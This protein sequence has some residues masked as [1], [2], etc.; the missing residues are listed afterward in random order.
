MKHN[1]PFI[2]IIIPTYNRPNQL[3]LCLNAIA[4]IEYP[5]NKFEVIVVDDGSSV[6]LKP[7]VEP[8]YDRLPVTLIR[9]DNSGPAKARNLGASHAKGDYLAFTDDDCCPAPDWL[10]ILAKQFELTPDHMIGGQTLNSLPENVFSQASHELICYLYNYY[11]SYL[12]ESSFFTSNHMAMSAEGFHKIY[13]FDV[14]FPFA[15]GEDRELCD[16]W[17]YHGYKMIYVA[18]AVVYHS[19]AMILKQFWRQHFNYG[20][21]AFHFHQI[22]QMRNQR[23]VKFE[24]FSFY[25][26]L[27]FF[28]FSQSRNLRSLFIV[29]LLLCSQV[30]GTIGYILEKRRRGNMSMN[31]VKK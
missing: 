20:R 16:R 23:Q 31:H 17:L 12:K 14:T 5:D 28:P 15:G 13:G 4:G 24:S 8:F 21:G 22:R 1:S 6:D 30:A 19:H 11:N 26:N 3:T 7:V 9:Q 27:V 29:P 2:S 18:E 25:W 10:E